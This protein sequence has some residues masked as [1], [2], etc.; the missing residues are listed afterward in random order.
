VKTLLSTSLRIAAAS[1]DA[2]REIA[3]LT[4]DA[5]PTYPS[6]TA[7]MTVVVTRHLHT[8]LAITQQ[9]PPVFLTMTHGVR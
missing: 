3:L 8:T 4:S 6:G 2:T 5:T 7:L 9:T 1:N